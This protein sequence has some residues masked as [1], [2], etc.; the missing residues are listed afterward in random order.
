[1]PRKDR[2]RLSWFS[3]ADEFDDSKVTKIADE[4]AKRKAEFAN[5]K[6]ARDARLAALKKKIKDRG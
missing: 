6:A 1:M 2:T 4:E 3:N 5:D